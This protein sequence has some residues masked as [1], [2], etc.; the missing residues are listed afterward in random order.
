MD[1]SQHKIKAKF[2]RKTQEN[3]DVF[4]FS[5]KLRPYE[6][7]NKSSGLSISTRKSILKATAGQISRL[8]FV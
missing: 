4:F 8:Q 6:S 1:G 7:Q 2:G 5:S 3:S